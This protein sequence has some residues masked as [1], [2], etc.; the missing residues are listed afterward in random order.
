MS[1]KLFKTLLL[2]SVILMFVF[3]E[4][5]HSQEEGKVII[6]SPKV[7]KV[8]DRQERDTYHLFQGFIDFHSAIFHVMSD[9]TYEIHIT[10]LEK[11]V[12]KTQI[13]RISKQEFLKNYK[14]TIDY[15]DSELGVT[16]EQWKSPMIQIE[17]TNGHRFIGNLHSVS[18]DSIVLI[19]VETQRLIHQE[20]TQ[21]TTKVNLNDISGLSLPR[22]STFFKSVAWGLLPG[23]IGAFIGFASGDDPSGWFSLTAVDKAA[24]L[25]LAFGG[26][27]VS[28]GGTIGAL[29]GVDVDVPWE[30]K[31]E[32]E[33]RS[34]LSQLGI[35]QYHSRDV[36]RASPWVGV[37]SPPHGKEVSAMG[38]R[39]RFYFTPR[40]GLELVYGR[41]GW[42]EYSNYEKKQLEYFSGG[43]F[44]SFTRKR[45]INPFVAWGWGRNST[46][47]QYGNNEYEETNSRFSLNFYGGVEM[48]LTNW[49]SLEGRVGNIL[50]LC[51]GGHLNFQLS[52]TFGP[53]L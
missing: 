28:I 44:I 49:L 13:W 52:L 27:G 23:A 37:I 11:G 1:K 10:Y 47:T 22:K 19:N 9:T 24:I 15:F 12:Q 39:L 34:I 17:T 45:L 21:L 7:G 16:P 42:F 32:V 4:R 26:I 41:T 2:L 31:S 38:G 3:V 5:S 8:I 46:T 43:F 51:E 20:A 30:E 50:V 25:G 53:N 18:A 36:L 33:R 29:K 35:G 6:I 48:P 40:S 14:N